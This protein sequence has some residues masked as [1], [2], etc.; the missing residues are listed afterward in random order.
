MSGVTNASFRLGMLSWTSAQVDHRYNE[1][2]LEASLLV[3]VY[4][5]LGGREIEPNADYII[6]TFAG[7]ARNC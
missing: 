3:A 6:L 5:L 7:R 4:R 1:R 2:C